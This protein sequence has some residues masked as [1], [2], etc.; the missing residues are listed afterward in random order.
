MHAVDH[1]T[2]G[3]YALALE[4][5]RRTL[6]EQ[7]RAVAEIRSRAGTLLS[8]AAIATSFLGSPLLTH[9]PNIATWFAIGAFAGLTVATLR[10]LWPRYEWEFSI[11]PVTLIETYIEAP[12][13]Q[14]PLS[15]P[16]LHRDIAIHM[17][18]SASRN[19]KE[20]DLLT[21]AF[22]IAGALLAIEIVASVF[23]IVGG[24]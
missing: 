18:E 7:E 12:D 5:G 24:T 2:P 15:L 6:E 4:E 3:G 23:S 17:D 13:A 14:D 10:V 1:A 22:R 11:Q 8:A 21:R 20:L 16:S 19:Q 9:G